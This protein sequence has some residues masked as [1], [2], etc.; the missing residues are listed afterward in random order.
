MSDRITATYLIE[1][2]IDPAD[3]AK[4]MAGEQSSGTFITLPG[5]TQALTERSAARVEEVTPLE[6][7]DTPSLTGGIEGQSYTRAKVRLS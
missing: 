6:T 3:A 1:T 4:S 7:V 2:P 5:E